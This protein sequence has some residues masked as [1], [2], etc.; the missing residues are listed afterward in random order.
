MSGGANRIFLGLGNAVPPVGESVSQEYELVA[1]EEAAAHQERTLRAEAGLLNDT[2][3]ASATATQT[4]TITDHPDPVERFDDN[5]QP[6]I[7]IDEVETG[8]AKFR[9][10][11]TEDG[12]P[13]SVADV[14]QLIAGF[15]DQ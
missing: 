1:A 8:I 11:T 15:N 9:Q 3:R 6:G 12:E 13:V 10:G 5:A 2:G 14:E 4:V 7:Q